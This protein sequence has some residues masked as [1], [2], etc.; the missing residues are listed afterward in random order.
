[1]SNLFKLC[2]L[3]FI[4]LLLS[5]SCSSNTKKILNSN[6]NNL[7]KS[8]REMERI[9]NF[10]SNNINFE[11]DKKIIDIGKPLFID[12]LIYP[13]LGILETIIVS[14][15]SGLDKLAVQTLGDQLFGIFL[16]FF[17][18]IPPILLPLISKLEDNNKEMLLI[19]LSFISV[20]ISLIVGFTI[21]LIVS[22]NLKTVLFSGFFISGDRISDNI[23]DALESYFKIKFLSFPIC[24]YCGVMFSIL[25]GNMNF[26]LLIKSNFLCN[27]MY[28][29][30]N[31]FFVKVYGLQGINFLCIFI[32]SLKSAIFTY[33][34]IKMIGYKKFAK[35][36]R[37]IY[38]DPKLFS[39]RLFE[40]F[41]Y[42]LNNGILLQFKN[43][44]RKITYMKINTKILSLDNNGNLLGIHI[45]LCKFYDLFYLFFKSINSVSSILFPK[46]IST[47]N[48]SNRNL[49]VNRFLLWINRIG[50]VQILLCIFNLAILSFFNNE[51][52]LNNNSIKFILNLIYENKDIGDSMI[53]LDNIIKTVLLTNLTCYLNGIIGFYEIL[54]QSNNKYKFHSMLSVSFSLLTLF[55][56]P[57][58]KNL[59]IVW[60][61][62]LIFSSI[63]YLIL[64][65][66]YNNI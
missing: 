60:L 44:V 18:F 55:T 56:I 43:I 15:F 27:L 33:N 21:S 41:Y 50:L 12:H 7:F 2:K 26:D 30:L 31:P 53:F 20:L 45:I 8:N 66:Y 61:S 16:N 42:F 54:L 34:F 32:D 57:Y 23:K 38:Y 28:I 3:F 29:L 64:K 14:K 59:Q 47:V 52:S 62:S 24:L 4:L 10:D 48:S 17:S 37:N 22:L 35:Y 36:F 19:D 40:R 13:I 1:M 11:I 25:K 51:N 6:I 46:I 65:Y 49:Y 5:L 9:N 39:K 58:Y 63:K